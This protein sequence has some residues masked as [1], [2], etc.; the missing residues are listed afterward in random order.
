MHDFIDVGNIKVS[1]SDA[2]EQRIVVASVYSPLIPDSDGDVMQKED[3]EK[4]AHDFLRA[5]KLDQIDVQHNNKLSPG[6]SVV[7]SFIARKGDPDFIEGSWVVAVHV[8]DDDVWNAIKKGEI[9]G[10]SMEA[11]V[12]K[13]PM[14]LSLEIPPVVNGKTTVTKM[15]NADADGHSHEFFV[16]FDNTGK[17]MG[18]RTSVEKGH[19]HNIRAGTMTEVEQDHNHR[20][21]FVESFST[22][23]I[24]D[25]IIAK[26]EAT[27][28]QVIAPITPNEE[29]GDDYGDDVDTVQ[30]GG[31]GSG[32]HKGVAPGEWVVHD[33]H[34]GDIHSAHSSYRKAMNA[35]S[36][37]NAEHEKTAVPENGLISGRYGAMSKD[38]WDK[39]HPVSKE[40][41]ELV[42]KDW[43]NWNATHGK[44]GSMPTMGTQP[45]PSTGL[46]A[47]SER[48]HADSARL[49]ENPTA[50]PADHMRLAAIHKQLASDL[51]DTGE[52]HNSFTHN[53]MAMAHKDKADEIRSRAKKEE[54][55]DDTSYAE[56]VESF[57]TAE[58]VYAKKAEQALVQKDWK[59]WDA[60]KSSNAKTPPDHQAAAH[61]HKNQAS[62]LTSTG[63]SAAR[64]S[65]HTTAATAHE[66]AANAL[67]SGDDK[68]V[69]LGKHARAASKLSATTF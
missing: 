35:M 16:T 5:K 57:N 33:E 66:N 13:T 29:G 68:A 1:K 64:V 20:F 14:E 34:T 26:E 10:F 36:K 49:N 52:F 51:I 61:W 48:A 38:Y 4:M 8:P 30:K 42:Q 67:T 23:I 54:V 15:G 45:Q 32:R 3:I 27:T 56:H 44:G 65:A 40:E 50:H 31:A 53:A 21:S 43:A 60:K 18:G 12:T 55:S 41:E 46:N 39:Q 2:I 63:G 47:R 69:T 59:A 58:A 28:M 37:L 19:F 11:L 62:Y 22:P 24:P 17:F 9:N 7:E 25:A 6:A